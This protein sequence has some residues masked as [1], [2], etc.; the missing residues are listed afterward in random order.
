MKNK[1]ILKVIVV[2]ALLVALAGTAFLAR[3]LYY[4][5]KAKENA[6]WEFKAEMKLTREMS[7]EEMDTL[8]AEFNEVLDDEEV[9]LPVV[10]ELDL[11]ATWEVASEG[12]AVELAR[13]ASGFQASGKQDAILFVVSDKDQEMAGMLAERIGA[14]FDRELKRKQAPPSMPGSP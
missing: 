13:Q 10:E 7:A 6:R 1:G 11:I 2:L 5:Q 3:R 9:L 4:R 12:E 14:A 8:L